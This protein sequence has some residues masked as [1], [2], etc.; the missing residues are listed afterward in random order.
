MW[1]LLLIKNMVNITS[2]VVVIVRKV[3]GNEGKVSSNGKSRGELVEN[4][5]KK[6]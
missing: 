6:S 1:Y 5:A 2:K 3:I 4:I